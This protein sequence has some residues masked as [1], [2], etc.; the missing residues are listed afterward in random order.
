[1]STNPTAG[2]LELLARGLLH[3]ELRRRGH[4]APPPF[5]PQGDLRSFVLEAEQGPVV[6]YNTAG[7]AAAADAVQ[8]VGRP[9]RLLI[10][11]WHEGMN[12][13]PAIG[14]P[15]FVH[16]RD[17]QQ[18]ERTIPV[19]GTFQDRVMLGDDLE[20]GPSV[21][22]TA[23]ATFYLWDSG[24]HRYLFVGDS[25]WVQDGVWRAVLLGESDRAAFL[26]TLAL[27]QDLDFDVLV[28]W[29]AQRGSPALETLT[30]RQKQQQLDALA[31]RIR[32]GRSGP[33][34]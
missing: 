26:D 31:T 16:Q 3:G 24:E 25:F 32:A 28:P 29:P 22:H 12:A 10:N 4:L 17:R 2:G 23:G 11:H 20:V 1:M 8:S 15:T 18:L 27:M 7:L 5:R 14:A 30:P 34:T 33:S 21:A 13:D 9:R 6:V 19:H